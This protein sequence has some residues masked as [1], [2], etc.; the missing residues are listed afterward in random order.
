[1]LRKIKKLG[2]KANFHKS[3]SADYSFKFIAGTEVTSI[4]RKIY[5]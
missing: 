5:I 2:F 1:M 3:L 4:E